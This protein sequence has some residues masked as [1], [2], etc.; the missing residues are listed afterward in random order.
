M[1]TVGAPTRRLSASARRLTALIRAPIAPAGGL[2]ARLALS[3]AAAACANIQP[4]PG[5]PPDTAAPELVG[6]FPES[7]AVLPGFHGAVEF[8]FNEVI[9]EG[10]QP[11]QGLGTGDLE[12][13]V[14]LSPTT[15]VPEVRWHRRRISVRP[16]EGWQPNRVYR[17]ELLPGVADV[18]Q[19]RGKAEAVVTFTTGAPP[20]RD[21]LSGKVYDWRAG[22]PAAGALVEAILQPDSLPYRGLADSSGW[23]RLGPLPR[24]DYLVYGVIDDNKNRRRDPREAWDTVRVAAD[25]IRPAELYAFVHD[26]V[27]PRIESV[28]ANDSVTATIT[29][30]QPLDPFQRLDPGAATLRRLPDSTR[31]PVRALA[32]RDSAAPAADT[33]RAALRRP[34]LSNRLILRAGEPWHAGD[35]LEVELAGVRTVSGVAGTVRAP[36]GIER[37]KPGR[38]PGDT[39]RRAPATDSLRPGPR[40]SL[41]PESRDSLRPRPGGP[42]PPPSP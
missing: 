13:L 14:I 6:T 30:A 27:P 23:F 5:G 11:S 31:I 19:N 1:G 42:S 10:S 17:V 3:L 38:L 8:R 15:R 34:P 22:R 2:T 39:G 25:S 41:R 21:T 9:S 32:Q 33:G 37:P 28:T 35:R 16:A 24:G 36:L 20:P 26:T 18:R 29:F 40:D 12:R 4:P 7:L